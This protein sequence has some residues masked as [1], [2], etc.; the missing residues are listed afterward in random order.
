MG[1]QRAARVFVHRTIRSFSFDLNGVCFSLTV[2]CTK[3]TNFYT[4]HLDEST[5]LERSFF[6]KTIFLTQKYDLPKLMK[7]LRFHH[8]HLSIHHMIYMTPRYTC[9]DSCANRG[10]C[11]CQGH[12]IHVS[13]VVQT[14]RVSMSVVSSVCD[15]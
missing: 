10:A 4:S 12:D 11:L 7:L 1:Y 6:D 14:D 8:L 2:E 5:Y 9:F 13:I 15:G 3:A